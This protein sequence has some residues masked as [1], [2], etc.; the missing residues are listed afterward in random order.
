MAE[1]SRLINVK[2]PNYHV[3]RQNQIDANMR[4]IHQKSLYAF[5]TLNDTTVRCIIYMPNLP[6]IAK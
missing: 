6:D 5:S 4:D 2:P 3:L 1:Q